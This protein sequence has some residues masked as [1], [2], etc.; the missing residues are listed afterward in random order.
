MDE[1]KK[2]NLSVQDVEGVPVEK[3]RKKISI[4]MI[5]CIVFLITTGIFW[6]NSEQNAKSYAAVQKQYDKLKSEQDSLSKEVSYYKEQYEAIEQQLDEQNS[7]IDNLKD[8]NSKKQDQIDNLK[9]KNSDL[10]KRVN[11]LKSEKKKLKTENASLKTEAEEASSSSDESG[12]GGMP[13]PSDS[14]GTMVWLSET[15]SKYHSIPDCGR[16]NP[17]K[18][19]QVSESEAEAEGYGRCSKCF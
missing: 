2:D 3:K 12:R 14:Q 19:W 13:A 1:R 11:T 16:M 4:S 8:E 5:L 15:G 18:A 7:E 6:S 10:K 17:D 9:N